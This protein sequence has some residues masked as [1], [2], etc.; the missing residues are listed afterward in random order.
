MER[1]RAGITLTLMAAAAALLLALLLSSSGVASAAG[2]H[3]SS[4]SSNKVP[5]KL[6]TGEKPSGKYKFISLTRKGG[7]GHKRNYQVSCA[8]EGGPSCYVGCRPDCPNSCFVYCDYCLSFCRT[9]RP[10]VTPAR[11]LVLA[12]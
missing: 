6:K 4:S 8:D 2:R 3:S 1:R 12:S 9:S 5:K 7:F 10:S 11:L